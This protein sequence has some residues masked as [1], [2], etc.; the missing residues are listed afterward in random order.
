MKEFSSPNQAFL[1]FV[2]S[3]PECLDRSSFQPLDEPNKYVRYPLNSWPT[4]ISAAE[5]SEI[6]RIG[7]G[8]SRLI[9]SI[10]LRFFGGDPARLQEFYGLPPAHISMIARLLKRPGCLEVAIG[11]GD[12]IETARGLQFL[13]LNF[14]SNIGGWK[15]EIYADLYRRV[16]VLQRFFTGS[17][18]DFESVKTVQRMFTHVLMSWTKYRG[19]IQDEL[20]TMFLSQRLQESQPGAPAEPAEQRI[21]RETLAKLGVKGTLITALP[22]D[23]QVRGT[24]LYVGDLR[25]HVAIENFEHRP[26]PALIPHLLNGDSIILNGPVAPVLSDKK[27]LALL[28]ERADSPSLDA[29]ERELVRNHLPWT[30]AVTPSYTTFEGRRAYLPDLLVAERE[31]MVLKTRFGARGEGVLIG[32]CTEPEPWEE[33]VR[34]ALQNGRRIAQEFVQASPRLHQVGASG[35]ALCDVVWGLFVFGETFGGSFLRVA[36]SGN[37]GVINSDQGAQE[38]AVFVAKAPEPAL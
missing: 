38:S 34:D 24:R 33:A 9:K 8:F 10:P 18:F 3:N 11:R 6:E 29:N 32:R 26:S 14:G 19:P 35:V 17:G 22:S 15:N 2:E 4:F 21:Y 25:I 16:P 20:N 5:A 7:V 27:N 37:Q 1:R 23:L 13:E 31:R 28:S 30:R 36:S 12:F